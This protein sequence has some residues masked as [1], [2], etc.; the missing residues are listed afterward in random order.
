MPVAEKRPVRVAPSDPET[1]GLWDDLGRLA[2][3]V[4]P[5]DWTLIGGLMVQ[6]HAYEA[7][8]MG[9]RVTTDIDILGDA[10]KQ[11]AIEKIARALDDD[12]FELE[13]PSPTDS[14][15][16][17][18]RRGDLIVDLLAPDGLRGDPP[19]LGGVLTVQIPGGSQAL[20]R[21]EI[22][23]VEINGAIAHVR[24]PTLLGAVLIKARSILV[25]ADPDAQRADLVLLLSLI[26]DPTALAAQLKGRERNWLRACEDQLGL[27]DPVLMAP[28]P[29]SRV[30]RARLAYRLLAG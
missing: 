20:A 3:R 28:F 4:L 24:R 26:G 19:M 23:E 21:T 17:R 15:S 8:E 14:V 25:H 29:R 9:V 11:K 30:Q 2:A 1:S 13:P 16:H 6:L 27:E 10:R 5:A 12:G 7:G 22:V 18:W